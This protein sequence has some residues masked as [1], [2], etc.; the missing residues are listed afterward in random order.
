[1]H[2]PPCHPFRSAEARASYLAGYERRAAH[3]PVPA[4]DAWVDTSFGRTC[5]RI[6]GP[7]AAPPLVL[8]PGI[9]ASSLMWSEMVGPLSKRRRVIAVDAIQDHGLSVSTRMLRCAA[10]YVAWL[11]EL[12]VGLGLE[13]GTDLVAA[14]Y[15]GWMAVEHALVHPERLRRMVLIAPVGAV[16]RLDSG[17]V[18]RAL[19]A[20]V[21]VRCCFRRFMAWL[22]PGLARGDGAVRAIFDEMVDDGFTSLRWFKPRRPVYPRRLSD[23]EW[24]RLAVPT[25]F[26]AGETDVVLPVPRAAE[27][28]RRVAPQVRT[29]VVPGVGHDLFVL[30]AEDASA[31]ILRFLDA[32]P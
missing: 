3:W 21:P 31:R 5:A 4:E 12:F 27:R 18:A 14:S 13:G 23:D 7:I 24:A 10:D 30:K 15:G 32:V 16:L 9:G 29:E 11:E 26:L 17:F 28:L 22:A 25:L 2:L 19:L 1:M 20:R 6:S 8:L